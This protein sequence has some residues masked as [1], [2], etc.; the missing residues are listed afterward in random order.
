MTGY[1]LAQEHRLQVK[2]E[3]A[4]NH[5]SGSNQRGEG[6]NMGKS[7]DFK[8]LQQKIKN[9]RYMQMMKTPN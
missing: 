5:T 4:E 1:G 6:L 8:I 7:T 2:L 3:Y 9:S